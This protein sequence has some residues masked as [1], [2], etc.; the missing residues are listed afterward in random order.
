MRSAR[1]FLPR[2]A[3]G[4]AA[5]QIAEQNLRFAEI[6]ADRVAVIET[7]HIRWQGTMTAFAADTAA[8][9]AFLQV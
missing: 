1:G 6:A 7:G 2:G 9:S 8:Q 3:G 4:T 5:D